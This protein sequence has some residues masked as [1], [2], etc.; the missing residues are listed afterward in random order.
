MLSSQKNIE[1]FCKW[2]QKKDTLCLHGYAAANDRHAVMT[3]LNRLQWEYDDVFTSIDAGYVYH[4][5]LNHLVERYMNSFKKT[6]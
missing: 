1:Q 3:E 5:D 4:T 6:Q 2:L